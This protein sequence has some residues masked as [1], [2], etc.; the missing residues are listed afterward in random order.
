LQLR[1][2]KLISQ[3]DRETLSLLF[4]PKEIDQCQC[5]SHPHRYYTVCFATKEAVGKALGTEL[6]NIGWNEIGAN[7]TDTKVTIKVHGQA[8]HQASRCGV[9]QWLATWW[10]WDA[11]VLVHVLAQ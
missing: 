11:Y 3:Y 9:Q 7:V 5:A 4:T 2:G 8:S 10:H 6:I 1:I